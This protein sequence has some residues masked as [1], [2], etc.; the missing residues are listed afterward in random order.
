MVAPP[1]LF[2]VLKYT[3]C[4][5][6]ETQYSLFT[7]KSLNFSGCGGSALASCP[8][9]HSPTPPPPVTGLFLTYFSPAPRQPLAFS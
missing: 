7:K 3:N 1:L 4:E 9:S 2:A 8:R 6:N 5:K